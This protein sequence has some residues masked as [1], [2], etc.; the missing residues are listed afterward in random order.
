MLSV[1][2]MFSRKVLNDDY[3]LVGEPDVQVVVTVL[4]LALDSIK[5]SKKGILWDAPHGLCSSHSFLA[6]ITN[7]LSSRLKAQSLYDLGKALPPMQ[8]SGKCCGRFHSMD[9]ET[10]L[11]SNCGKHSLFLKKSIIWCAQAVVG[12]SAAKPSAQAIIVG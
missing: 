12:V 3:D 10:L 9:I 6:H 11:S 2:K 1:V 5:D 4:V 7:F 8:W